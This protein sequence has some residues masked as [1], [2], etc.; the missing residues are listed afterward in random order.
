MTIEKGRGDV[1]WKLELAD[2][3]LEEAEFNSCPIEIGEEI[4]HQLG[5]V[6]IGNV[7]ISPMKTEPE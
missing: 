2:A 4:E 1:S 6:Y 5:S 3:I 7:C